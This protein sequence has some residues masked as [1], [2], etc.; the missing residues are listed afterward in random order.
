MDKSEIKVVYRYDDL[1]LYA[2]TVT[3]DYTDRSPISGRWQIPGYCTTVE[4]PAEKDGYNRVW[5]GDEWEY[6]E[7][8]KPPTPPEP[9]TEEKLEALDQQYNAEVARLGN[10]FNSAQL[11]GDSEVMTAL[12]EEMTSL[13]AWY[14]EEYNKIVNGGK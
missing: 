3:L 10:E 12:Q 6:V 9:T 4:P 14:D 11:R 5:S 8:P 7:I 13:D 2:G 1:G